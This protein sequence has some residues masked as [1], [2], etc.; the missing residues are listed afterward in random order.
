MT[1]SKK[2]TH[3]PKEPKTSRVRGAREIFG[4]A[5]IRTE[6]TDRD[7]GSSNSDNGDQPSKKS[8]APKKGK[9]PKEE[10]KIINKPPEPKEL[11][12]RIE[13][14]SSKKGVG[15]IGGN[16]TITLWLRIAD[17]DPVPYDVETNITLHDMK[18]KIQD[19][20]QF[21]LKFAKIHKMKC[22]DGHGTPLDPR[23][24][25]PIFRNHLI[26]FSRLAV[27]E[28]LD[29]KDEVWLK[30]LGGHQDHTESP[31]HLG[32]SASSTPGS[33]SMLYHRACTHSS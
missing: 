17:W 13:P 11:K 26:N 4:I 22:F 32:D 2:D 5:S 21:E 31:H 10:K 15:K 28:Q 8:K 3:A 6:K 9:D 20:E 12:A 16:Q 29:D 19:D 14:K 24:S 25:L 1:D 18:L 7:D 23:F 27:G 30:L 33:R